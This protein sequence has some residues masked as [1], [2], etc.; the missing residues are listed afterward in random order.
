MPAIKQ[1]SPIKRNRR[2][3]EEI[4]QLESQIYC[5]LET[6][7]PQSVRHVFYR[8]TDPRLPVSI[9]K[10]EKGYKQIQ[11]RCTV[12]RRAGKIPYG[13]FADLSRQGYFTNTYID[14][15]DFI[16]SMQGLYRADLWADADYRCEVWVESRSI[17]GVLLKDCRELA[18]D[19]YPCGGFSSMT[20]AHDAA[21]LHNSLG[22][23]R[24]LKIF[25]IGDYDPAGVLIDQSLE[26]ELRQ[27][28]RPD[29]QLIFE[30]IAIN[31]N[32]IETYDLPTKPRKK[33]EKR[34]QNIKFTVEAEAMP[35]NIMRCIL[36]DYVESL[37]PVNALNIARI[38]EDSERAHL[39]YVAEMLDDG[40]I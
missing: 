35:A 9:A 16:S 36:R 15:A 20:F 30:R 37:L 13:W 38:A 25:Y 17:A 26:K 24:P 6:D 11:Q 32:Q 5:V 23:A 18:V 21:M 14:A 40:S 22:D 8:M 1:P 34:V 27:H 4:Q 2:S 3:K 12:M 29:I 10:S 19:L 28:L 33:L 31:P 7:H 39:S